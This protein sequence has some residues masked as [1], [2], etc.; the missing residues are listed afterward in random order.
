MNLRLLSTLTVSILGV[1]I[2]A[3]AASGESEEPGKA[4]YPKR[5]TRAESFLGIHFDFHAGP[6]CN[7]IGK[8]TT[9]QMIEQILAQVRP[10][11]LQID[12]KGHRGLS[13]YP[14]R[15]GNPAPGFVGDPLRLWREV[16]AEHGVS[17][18]MH[19]SGV[20]DD[21]AIV[22]NPAWAAVQSDGK[23]N[24][25]ATSV[26]GPYVD[27]LLIPQLKEL[28]DVYGVDGVW[29][30]GECWAAIPDYSEAALAAFRKEKGI[31]K[32]P[33]KPTDPGYFE[34]MQFNR[35]GFRRYLRHWVDEIH[36]HNPRFQVASNWA[37][38]DHMLEPV[39][40]NVDFLSGDYSLQDSVNA[41]RFSARC[42]APQGKP[43]DLMAWAFSGKHREPGRSLKSVVQLQRE[44]A[45]VLAQGGGFQ[46]YFKQKRDGSIYDWQMK[47]MAE[48]ARF[49]RARQAVC[50]RAQSVPQIALLFSRE[51]HYRQSPR[52]FVPQSAGAMAL[53]GVLQ[54]LVESQNVVDIRSE[55]HLAGR[56]AEYPLIV[57]PE[58]DYLDPAFKSELVEYVQGGGNLL[59]IGPAAAKLFE[60]ELD[61]R[62]AG[63]GMAD[64]IRYLEHDGWLAGFKTGMQEATLGQ[65]AQ[66]FGR[67]YTDDD[68]RNP[69]QPAASIRQ[70]GKGRIAATYFSIGERYTNAK[71]SVV[72]DFVDSL[73]RQLFPKPMVEVAG[74]HDV[75]VTL[76]RHQGKLAVNLI[77][78]AG[79]HADTRVYVFDEIPTVGPLTVTLRLPQTPKSITLEPEH[80]SI[81][82]ESQGGEIKL[83][84]PRLAIHD[85]LVVE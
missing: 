34:F 47:L 1:F 22:K 6:D 37:F 12:C 77:N 63:K 62:L 20:A 28:S 70:L 21:E 69:S 30:D 65:T 35:E 9:R 52:L 23:R 29:V 71:T 42:L 3:G 84:L 31:E 81:P 75:E 19:Y 55:H 25:R 4:S 40:A 11:Y 10:D 13:S 32:T 67:L 48:T 68:P 38:S 54:C 2:V 61:V 85:I 78:T 56:M 59:L 36:R 41:A 53:R 66:G 79:P 18:F 7:E 49:C 82:F 14:T 5:L 51:A 16:T 74:S 50:H 26:F 80:K 27:K 73:V 57:I 64:G 8:N 72:R 44:A 17:L 76:M 33:R 46:A 60:K 24:T 15:V 43:W 39:T 58:W 83:T 45:I